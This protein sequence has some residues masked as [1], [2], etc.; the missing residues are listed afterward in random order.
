MRNKKEIIVLPIIVVILSIIV[1]GVGLF[2]H[3]GGEPFSV[4][5]IYGEN[6]KMFGNGIYAHEE[7]V[8]Y[9]V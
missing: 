3:D 4:T 1:A 6:I 5:N 9:F 8:K 2:W 7:P